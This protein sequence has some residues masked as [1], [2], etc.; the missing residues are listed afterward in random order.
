MTV[1]ADREDWKT[2]YRD[3]LSEMERK[4]GDWEARDGAL[5]GVASRLAI[6]AMGRDARVDEHLSAIL[7][8]IKGGEPEAQI[9][10][11]LDGLSAA[12]LR[13]ESQ[14]AEPVAV[15]L[16]GF[17]ASLAIEPASQKRCID[18][19]E[20]DGAGHQHEALEEL[21][22]ELNALLQA[23]SAAEAPPTDA[24]TTTL[25]EVV[26]AFV[27]H[28]HDVPGLADAVTKL[29]QR[30]TA[31][32]AA[33]EQAALLDRLG[34][35]VRQVI[36]AM[37]EDREELEAFL[38]QV[39]QQ[40]TRFEDWATGHET[41]SAARRDDA[42]SLERRVEAQVGGLESDVEAST[43][44]ADLKE[45]VQL[46]LDTIA[47]QLRVFR[48]NE[49]RRVEEAGRRNAALRDEVDRL[50][51]RTAELAERCSAQEDR[52]MHDLL[53]GVHTRYAYDQRLQEEFQ[54]WQRH[55]QP[56]S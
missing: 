2:K 20:A 55:G 30:L 45:R 38:E 23:P 5:R 3:L 31:G 22:R 40:L 36:R 41:D 26:E 39:T 6:T 8:A 35:A 25:P 42:D 10:G 46:R 33:Q 54:R 18:A 27:R 28:V 1:T 17:V 48:R 49:A 7:E 14:P 11:E 9:A 44:T 47:E 19:L 29:R 16:S 43:D 37:D 12:V 50:R 53:T 13:Q 52:L 4:E 15:D 24:A 32:L 56:L 34:A 21:A 51:V